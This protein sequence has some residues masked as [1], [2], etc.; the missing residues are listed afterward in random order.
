MFADRNSNCRLLPGVAV[1]TRSYYGASEGG[2]ACASRLTVHSTQCFLNNERSLTRN[3]DSFSILYIT[4]NEAQMECMAFYIKA[5]VS[6]L[7]LRSKMAEG[8]EKF[9]CLDYFTAKE[10]FGGES[11]ITRFAGSARDLSMQLSMRCPGSSR[12][13]E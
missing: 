1:F 7:P 9:R 10:H 2:F 13:L 12:K 5:C 4:T 11:R 6:Q 3:N 8:G